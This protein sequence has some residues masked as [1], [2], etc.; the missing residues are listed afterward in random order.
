MGSRSD[1]REP[2]RAWCVAP[3]G[4]SRW[5]TAR[6]RSSP[7]RPPRERRLPA[8]AT[9]A[10][11]RRAATCPWAPAPAAGSSTRRRS[12]SATVV[13]VQL[14]WV[15]SLFLGTH[16]GGG[17]KPYAAAGDAPRPQ[18]PRPTGAFEQDVTSVGATYERF[19][20]SNGRLCTCERREAVSVLRDRL[21]QV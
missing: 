15:T 10:A 17:S 6:R 7:R 18:E 2:C 11:R 12:A 3:S 5:P 4:Q 19:R 13:L 14:P 9:A 16:I 1:R 20:H 21:I 8:P